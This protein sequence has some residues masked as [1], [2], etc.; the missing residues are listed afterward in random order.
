MGHN[1]ER[2]WKPINW[3][4]DLQPFFGI[5]GGLGYITERAAINKWQKQ[6]PIQ[7]NLPALTEQQRTAANNGGNGY[8]W[9]MSIPNTF[10]TKSTF[11]AGWQSAVW[12]YLR[13]RGQN[14]TPQEWFRSLDYDG[15]CNVDRWGLNRTDQNNHSQYTPF[16]GWIHA[17]AETVGTGSQIEFFAYGKDTDDG[18]YGLVYPYDF[19]NALDTDLRLYNYY[20]GIAVVV[21]SNLYLY[22]STQRFIDS[23]NEWKDVTAVKSLPNYGYT[24]TIYAIPVLSNTQFD[25]EWTTQTMRVIPL[26]GHYLTLTYENSNAFKINASH[27]VGSS[28]TTVTVTIENNTASSVSVNDLALYLVS[29]GSFNNVDDMIDLV[30]NNWINSSSH[31]DLTSGGKICAR[32]KN[33]KTSLSATTIPAGGTATAVVSFP[34]TSDG[35]GVY[36]DWMSVVVGTQL[37]RDS[38]VK[39]T[40]WL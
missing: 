38:N 23:P 22:T 24:G 39:K 14:R 4:A 15:Y 31:S 5:V 28:S 37:S 18:D 7:A 26:D 6:K 27:T 12:S 16:D 35:Y 9:G 33:I 19:I 32:Y 34:Y 11:M 8:A 36:D 17:S 40:I 3:L 10:T 1:S 30:D 21:G 13:P 25:G 2:L 20:V 29:D